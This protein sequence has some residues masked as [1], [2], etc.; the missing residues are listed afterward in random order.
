MPRH[1]LTEEDVKK[2]NERNKELNVRRKHSAA[3]SVHRLVESTML[4]YLR[5]ALTTPDKKGHKFY[6]D[7][8]NNF[9]TEAKSNPNSQAAKMLGSGLFSETTLSKLDSQTNKMMQRDIDFHTYRIRNTLF[10]KQQ[11]VFDDNTSKSICIICSRRAGKT[12]TNARL[13]VKKCLTPNTPTAYI[14]LTFSNGVRQIFDEVMEVAGQCE[15][16]INRSSKSE[17]FIEFSNGSSLQIFGNN[18]SAEAE[19]LRGFHY[20]LVIIE[21][22]GAQRNLKYLIDDVIDPLL[23]DFADSQLILTGTPPRNKAHYINKVWSNPNI[24]KYHWTLLDNPY[25]PD[26]DNLIKSVC[27]SHGLTIDAPFIRREYF[28]EM[29]VDTEAQV[30]K[31]YN[32]YTTIPNGFI[33]DR[34]YIGVDYGGIDYNAI[35]PLLVDS[36]NKKAYTYSVKKFNKAS[37]SEIVNNIISAKEEAVKKALELNSSFDVSKVQIITDTNEKSISYEMVTT[38]G[39]KNV[40]NAYKCDKQ[41]AIDQLAEW[42]RN[43]TFYIEKDGDLAFECENTMYK[44]DDQDNILNEIDDNIYHPDGMDALLYASRQF[45]FDVMRFKAGDAKKLN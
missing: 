37:V 5:E 25:I 34:M 42:L 2:S 6:E 23:K 11:E 16:A 17:G 18:N 3:T 41:M 44:R 28:G 7:F 14:H 36:K 13:I 33:P 12:Q 10:D 45:A 24:K 8:I 22:A 1:K 39:L 43:G 15:L 19:K 38:Y 4:D 32:T 20:K 21:E 26:R 35:V 31:G 27:D 9:L 30:Y 29:V 40:Y